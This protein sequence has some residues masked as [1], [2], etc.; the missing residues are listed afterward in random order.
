[1]NVDKIP[2]LERDERLADGLPADLQLFGQVALRWQPGAW[3]VGA[4]QDGCSDQISDL[5]IQP[6]RREE[7]AHRRGPPPTHGPA[8]LRLA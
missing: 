6:D 4:I 5:L 3:L 2:D 8:M 1:M 7:D